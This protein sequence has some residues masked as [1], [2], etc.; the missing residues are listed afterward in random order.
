M[1]SDDIHSVD[2]VSGWLGSFTM[3]NWHWAFVID[4]G[5]HSIAGWAFFITRS[6]VLVMKISIFHD[7]LGR[8]CVL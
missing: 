1:L 2:V 6:M 7:G 8:D 3:C 4:L 5:M